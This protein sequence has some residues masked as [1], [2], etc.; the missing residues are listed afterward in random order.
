MTGLLGA[1]GPFERDTDNWT[2]YCERLQQFFVSLV[3]RPR[4][5]QQRMDYITA[6]SRSGDV[7]HPLLWESGSGYETSSSWRTR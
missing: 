2:A 7:I 6:I 3:P 5:S 1:V 4:F